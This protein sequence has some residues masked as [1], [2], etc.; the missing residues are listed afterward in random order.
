M[1]K[2]IQGLFVLFVR[3]LQYSISTVRL[4]SHSDSLGDDTIKPQK[5]NLN[6][7]RLLLKFAHISVVRNTDI[8]S[9]VL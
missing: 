7:T 5:N 1:V 2:K 6:E 4:H 8:H 9:G 3:S